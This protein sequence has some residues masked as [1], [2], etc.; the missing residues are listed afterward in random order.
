MVANVI[1]ESERGSNEWICVC[2]LH[3]AHRS[4]K[5]II[6]ITKVLFTYNKKEQ[7]LYKQN[8]KTKKKN[9]VIWTREQKSDSS[10]WLFRMKQIIFGKVNEN[11][12][13]KMLNEW[14]TQDN[15][16]ENMKKEERTHES[17]Q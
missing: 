4:S 15:N 9:C 2:T 10:R 11:K 1:W 13:E 5:S 7:T 3:C 12:N 8:K 6:I 14:T 16:G 17:R